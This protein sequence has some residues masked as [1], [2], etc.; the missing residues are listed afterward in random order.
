METNDERIENI[1]AT[2]RFYDTDKIM[3]QYLR[4]LRHATA[5]KLKNDVVVD[6]T[7]SLEARRRVLTRRGA[8]PDAQ[9]KQT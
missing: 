7:T 1:A 2:L 6:W 4:L 5:L 8:F 9:E 3:D